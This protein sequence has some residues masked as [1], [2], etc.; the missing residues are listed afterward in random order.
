LLRSDRF[1]A[2]GVG[3]IAIAVGENFEIGNGIVDGG[4]EGVKAQAGAEGVPNG[5]EVV[6]RSCRGGSHSQSGLV[7]SS[8]ECTAESVAGGTVTSC[9]FVVCG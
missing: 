6:A 2:G 9:Q 8:A 5:P 3:A 7:F 1:L 4:E